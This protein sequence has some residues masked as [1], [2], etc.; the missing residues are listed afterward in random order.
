MAKLKRPAMVERLSVSLGRTGVGVSTVDEALRIPRNRDCMPKKKNTLYEIIALSPTF[1]SYIGGAGWG[2]RYSSRL[3]R[4]LTPTAIGA[5]LE[6]PPTDIIWDWF[7]QVTDSYGNYGNLLGTQ[8]SEETMVMFPADER[9]L[10]L[11]RPRLFSFVSVDYDVVGGRVFAV[12]TVLDIYYRSVV[13]SD[14]FYRE[15]EMS[16]GLRR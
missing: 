13:V 7:N 8:K 3:V 16:Y 2:I 4:S 15:Y 14:A 12:S 11:L 6:S 1:S 9:P 5:Y 10:V